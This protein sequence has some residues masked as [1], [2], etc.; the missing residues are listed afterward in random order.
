[1]FSFSRDSCPI[2]AV[3]VTADAQF[4]L[5]KYAGNTSQQLL[6]IATSRIRL[7]LQQR[8]IAKGG[9]RHHDSRFIGDAI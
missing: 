2:S 8:L 7:A 1:M 9:A 4:D 5:T 6:E 3:V